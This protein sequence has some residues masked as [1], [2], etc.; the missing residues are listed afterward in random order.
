MKVVAFGSLRFNRVG[1]SDDRQAVLHWLL[2]VFYRVFVI[3]LDLGVISSR[4]A[5]MPSKVFIS[6]VQIIA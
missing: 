5:L 2:T 4:V 1:E 3:V 6:L